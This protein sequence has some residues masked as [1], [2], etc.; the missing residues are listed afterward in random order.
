MHI[1]VDIGL[2]YCLRFAENDYGV[3]LVLGGFWAIAVLAAIQT[4]IWRALTDHV[5]IEQ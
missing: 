4:L 3:G 1:G 5:I 2:L